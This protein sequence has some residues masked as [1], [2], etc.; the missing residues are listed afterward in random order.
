MKKTLISLTIL[1]G[2]VG[3]NN[4]A[5][6]SN[7]V[8]QKNLSSGLNLQA[9]DHSVK[10]GDDFN[11]Y[12]NGLWIKET[13]IP[14]DKSSYGVGTIVHEQ[15]QKD[16]KAIIEQSANGKFAHGSNEQ[17]VGDLYQSY[18]DWDTR[19]KVGLAPLQAEF[20]QIDAISDHQALAVHFAAVNKLGYSIPFNLGQYV[21]FKDPNV[22]MM[23]T[24]QAGLG[25]PDREYYFTDDEASKEL[26]AKY[27]KHIETMLA[28]TGS[29]NAKAEAKIIFDLESKLA[30]HHMKKEKTRDMV[31]LYNKIPTAK[32]TD[33]MPDFNWQGFMKEAGVADID[34]LVVTQIDYMKALNDI[35]KDTSLDTWKT[36]LRWGVVNSNASRLTQAIDEQNFEFYG[37]TLRG[38][39]AQ[40][41]MWRRGVNVVNANIGEVVG[42]VYV[43]KHFPP[44]AKARMEELV[45]NLIKAYEVSI[46]NLD[47][48][49]PETKAQALDKLSKFTPK[50]GYPDIWR[51]YSA[52]DIQQ[53]DLFGN[54]KR[55]ALVVYQQNLDR[56]NG[57]VQKHEWQ[58]TPQTVNAY[59]NP[60][61]NEIVFPA[62][63]LQ[64][65]YFN[66]AAEDAVNY[67]AIGAVIGHEIGHGFD[68]S[69][70]TFDGDGVLRNWWTDA[71]KSEFKN[72][73]TKLVA[74]Y[75]EFEPLDGVHVNGT[76][77][78]GENIGD[79]GGL[80]ISLLAYKMSLNGK[81]APVIDN[82]SGEQRVFLGYAQSWSNKYRDKALKHQIKT[83]PHS[84]SM[85]R[86]NGV[87][88]NVPEFY[89]L[90]DVQPTDKL[91]LA[92]QER[93]KIW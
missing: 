77:T 22:Y 48:M 8:N 41:P 50:I 65:P 35:I 57:P 23:Y 52:L 27:L 51:D 49:T 81:E 73:T 44:E 16:V 32:L 2:L 33:I 17:K 61:L 19:N 54:L 87:V 82:F 89:E 80:S 10:P 46:K 56:Q 34:G 13:N 90:F 31:A 62:A 63:I 64:P 68:D 21:D 59:Y 74:Q 70:S 83:D 55:S 84:P 37:K 91:Y 86:V 39:K 5:H 18:V 40:Q 7:S 26:R 30:S 11:L 72:R 66:L 3:C 42:K 15:S 53:G 85:Y 45:A 78:L 76:F 12:A 71:D 14:D 6:I 1:L 4:S 75:D 20:K 47:W 88:R 25:L 79:L 43:K 36:F 24:W 93:V 29:N 38:V 9:I 60:P 92:P 58:M 28:L 67:G 69:G